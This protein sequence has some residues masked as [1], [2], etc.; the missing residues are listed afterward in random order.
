MAVS[1][2]DFLCEDKESLWG[3]SDAPGSCRSDSMNV[4]ITLV[5]EL[6]GGL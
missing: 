6:G 1:S 4:Q 5:A 3:W 2:S